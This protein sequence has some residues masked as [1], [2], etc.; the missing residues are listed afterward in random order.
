MEKSVVITADFSNL[1]ILNPK[2]GKDGKKNSNQKT[3][4]N[5]KGF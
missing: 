5:K 1:G 3:R 2:Y 4:N